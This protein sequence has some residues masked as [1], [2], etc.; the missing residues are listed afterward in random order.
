MHKAEAGAYLQTKAK[1]LQ[2][3]DVE[4]DATALE[5]PAAQ[6]ILEHAEAEGYGLIVLSSHGRTGLSAWN[7]SGVV[8]KI[9]LAA[10]TPVLLVRAYREAPVDLTGLKYRRV[11]VPLDGSA[12]AECVLP[13]A[14]RV[15]VCHGAKLLLVHLVCKPEMPRRAPLTPEEVGLRDRCAELNRQEAEHYLENLAPQVPADS[16]VRLLVADSIPASLHD[17]VS[18]EKVDL[19]ALSAHGYAGGTRWPYGSVALN[20]IAYGITPLL[21]VQDLSRSE[22][23]STQA[24]MAAKAQAGH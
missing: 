6:R 15:A 16:E 10:C 22:L 23:G 12:R 19:V 17:L 8:Q 1:Q 13:L 3:V 7:I 4:A 18:R 11:L 2:A 20:F 14:T 9:I 5:G 21:I 24:E